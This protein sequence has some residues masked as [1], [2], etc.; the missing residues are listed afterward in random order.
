MEA[1]ESFEA[2]R[3]LSEG[4]SGA[5]RVDLGLEG[6][7]DWLDLG[8]VP[9]LTLLFTCLLCPTCLSSPLSHPALPF[10]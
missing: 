7:W 6:C 8:P 9:Q 5:V 1:A 10:T 3:C 2:W 4:F